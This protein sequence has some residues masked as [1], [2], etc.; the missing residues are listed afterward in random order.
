VT[1]AVGARGLDSSASSS[2][3]C[4]KPKLLATAWACAACSS[5]WVGIGGAAWHRSGLDVSQHAEGG[6]WGSRVG[7]HFN[8]A[9]T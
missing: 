6:A 7:S 4:A 3:L 1:R 8:E 5:S 2:W 9:G